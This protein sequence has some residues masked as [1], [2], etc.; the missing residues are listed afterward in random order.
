MRGRAILTL[1]C[2][3]AGLAGCAAL[4]SNGPTAGR[5]LKAAGSPANQLGFTVVDVAATTLPPNQPDAAVERDMLSA[6]AA[7]TPVERSDL[8]RKG[9]TLAI[10]I[11]EVGI[12]L[13]GSN[14][15]AAAASPTAPAATGQRLAVQVDEDGR[16]AL[17]YIGRLEVAGMTPSLLSGI[18]E[19]RLRAFSQSPQA[20]VAITDSLENNAYVTGAVVRPGRYRLS[21][22]RERLLDVVTLAGGASV[23]I[24]EAELRLARGARAVSIRLG[25]IRPEDVA[26]IAVAPGDRIEILRRPR[27]YTVFGA[28]ERAAQLAFESSSLSLAEAVAR[29][30]G[31]SDQRADPTGV[32]LFRVEPGVAGE[33]PKPV[34][35]RLNMLDPTSYFLAQRIAMRDKDVIVFANASGNVPSKFISL[36]NQLF[37]PLITARVLTQ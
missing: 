35:Y 18:I 26:N 20:S 16:I 29:A 11:Y 6:L 7:A 17:P 8:I 34:I 28:A 30:G 33:A 25:E 24:D 1:L 14:A 37:S 9:D 27:S 32:F 12:S 15:G 2:M 31:P 3:M 10:S 36:L 21:S 5:I 23:G 19:G 13:F 22:A 4:P